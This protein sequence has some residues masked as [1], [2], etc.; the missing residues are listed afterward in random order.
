MG[1]LAGLEPTTS[2]VTIARSG[3]LSYSHQRKWCR[4]SR[5]ERTVSPLQGECLTSLATSAEMNWMCGRESH[6]PG[7]VLQTGA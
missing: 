1:W 5:F 7:P 3:Q 6:P 2:R 4:R